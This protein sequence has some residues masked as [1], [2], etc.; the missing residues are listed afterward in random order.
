MIGS[1]LIPLWQPSA[2][3]LRFRARAIDRR[4]QRCTGFSIEKQG[5]RR[6]ET[7]VFAGGDGD[8]ETDGGEVVEAAAVVAFH[9]IGRSS[10]L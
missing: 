5:R 4:V 10:S 7:A 9:A 1:F 3:P 2:A 8:E 6:E